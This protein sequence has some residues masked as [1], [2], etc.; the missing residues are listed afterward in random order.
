MNALHL[1]KRLNRVSVSLDDST[2]AIVCH[3]ANFEGRATSEFLSRL[4]E[5]YVHGHKLRLQAACDDDHA[6]RYS[7]PHP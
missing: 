5:D 4:I 3:L 2:F 1:G 6:D 7:G